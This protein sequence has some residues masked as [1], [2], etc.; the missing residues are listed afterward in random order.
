MKT[1][2]Q[3]LLDQMKE[4]EYKGFRIIPDWH[5]YNGKS[6]FLLFHD[7]KEIGQIMPSTTLEEIKEYIDNLYEDEK[8]VQ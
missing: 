7:D 6:D 3:Q 4:I 8:A 5:Y 1:Y 2:K